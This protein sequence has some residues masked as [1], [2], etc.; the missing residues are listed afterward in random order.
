[1]NWANYLNNAQ[2]THIKRTMFELLQERYQGNEEIIERVA[3]S[4]A[5]DKDVTDFLKFITDTYEAAYMKAVKDHR[6]Q[7]EKVGLVA[8]IRPSR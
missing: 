2:T 1:M 3:V 7:L 5:T 6:E 8:N 4:L